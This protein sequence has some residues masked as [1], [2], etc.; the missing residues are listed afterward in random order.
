[1]N[2][3]YTLICSV[4]FCCLWQPGNAVAQSFSK[5]KLNP[6]DWSVSLQTL[7]SGGSAPTLN[8]EEFAL[9]DALKTYFSANQYAQAY[10]HLLKKWPKNPSA[11]LLYIRAQT[12][13][14]LKK[15]AAAKKD[16][17]ASIQQHG[18]YLLA[19]Q[20]L[21]NVAFLQ[22]DEKL[23]HRYLTQAIA[24]GANNDMVYGQLGYLNLR[25]HSAFSAVAAYQQAYTLAPEKKQ[26]QQG[27]LLALSRAGA[28]HQ[29]RAMVDELLQRD[30]NNREL[31]L[32]RANAALGVKDEL[33]A[34]TAMEAAL[35]LGEKSTQNVRLA[36]QLNLSQG[37]VARAVDLVLANP[38]LLRQFPEVSRLL[39]WLS[40]RERW[41]QQQRL[42]ARALKQQ[43][44]Y[45][46]DQRGELYTQYARLELHRGSAAKARQHLD[47]ALNFNPANG[48][49]LLLL[50]D[51]L[52]EQDVLGRADALLT[53]A[54][55]LPECR[56]A[57]LLRRAQIAYQRRQYRAAHD[58]LQDVLNDN[59]SRRDLIPNMEVLMRLARQ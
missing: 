24:L 21:A 37:N 49:A 19:A 22:G 26:W 40:D 36:S 45:S 27:L 30:V 56:E 54:Q 28:Y 9:V 5:V 41:E 31:W 50:A 25:N 55:A 17:E 33:A 29:A 48:Q 42:L 38:A 32:H 35:R 16:Y 18:P 58:L 34:L 39:N 13:T 2:R 3:F 12:A 10:Q 51:I 57:A 1:M 8:T 7:S 53:R 46:P 4:L 11:A 47:R 52:I 23:A 43:S 20:S 15:Y 44:H 14:Q 59:P 6:P